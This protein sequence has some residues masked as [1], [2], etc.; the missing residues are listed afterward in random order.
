MRRPQIDARFGGNGF[1]VNLVAA[2]EHFQEKRKEERLGLSGGSREGEE[3][4]EEDW[5]WVFIGR[6]KHQYLAIFA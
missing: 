4:R 3:E 5:K 6:V 2:V 1:F